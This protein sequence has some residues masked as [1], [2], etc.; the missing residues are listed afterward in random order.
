MKTKCET[1]N[2]EPICAYCAEHLEEFSLPA[3]NGA[4]DLYDP[5]PEQCACESCHEPDPNESARLSSPFYQT[6]EGMLSP[7]YKERFKAE[8]KQTKIRYDKLHAMLVKADAGKLEFEPTCPLDLLR[9]QA[10]AMGQYLY[11]LEV[12]AQIEGIDLK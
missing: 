6:V 9:R 4:C 1:C 3:E 12:R 8:Y 11:C 10:A 7:D 2:H 5:R